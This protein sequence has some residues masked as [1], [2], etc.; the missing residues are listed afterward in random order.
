MA[1]LFHDF[2]F[3]VRALRKKP[4]FAVTAV[5]TLALG[6]GANVAVFSIVNALILRPYP[7]PELDRL[8]LLRA[9]GPKVVSEVRIAPAD[10]LDLQR[11][12]SIFQMLAAFRV[13]DSNLTGSGDTQSVVTAAVSPNFFELIGVQPTLGRQF[14]TEETE[15]GRDAV[16]IL[17]YGFW[18][19]HFSG[20]RNI[21]GRSIELDGRKMA[22]VG[23]M[24][25]H[26]RYPVATDLWMPLVL[27]PQTRAE[28]NAQAV[29]GRAIQVLARLRPEVSLN[30]AESEVQ[31][32]AARLQR[33][34]PDTHSDRSLSL[35]LL[36]REQYAFSAPL[37][38]TL[39]AAALFVL[40]LAA[41]N[42]FNLLLA[43][44]IDRQ[45]DVAVRTALG[46]S[47]LR[48]MQLYMGETV[49]LALVGGGTALIGSYLAVNFIRTS[50]PQ[51][52]TKW[53]AGW[54]SIHLDW[55][56]IEFAFI[57]TLL[58][59]ILFAVGASW[60]SG[61]PDLNHVLKQ[62]TRASGRR[63][64]RLRGILVTAQIAFA[65]VLLAGA[66]LMVQGFIRL[67][68][69]YKTFDPGHVLTMEITLPEQRYNDDAKVRAF[70]QQFLERVAALPG[71][72]SAGTVTNPPASNVDNARS[73]FAIEGQT[74]LRES[75][76]PSADL[77]SVSPD[78]FRSLRIPLLQGRD[79][80]DHDG[81]GAP[82]VAMISRTM[83]TRL[84]PGASA[85]GQRIKLGSPGSQANW[86]TIVGVVEDVKQNWW[87]SAA[88][89][90]I[91]RPFAQVPRRW[92]NFAIRTSFDP[93]SVASA[94]REAGHSLDPGVSLALSTMD[95]EVSDSLAPIRI[96]GILMVVFGAVSIALSALGIYG[97]LAHSVAQRTHEFGIRMALGAQRGDVLRLVIGQSWKLCAIG[98]LIGLP[99]AY[100]LVRL[101][102][103]LLYGV[104]AFSAV[105]F[106]V[107]AVALTA[108]A[109]LAGYLPAK[110]ATKVD[111]MLALRYE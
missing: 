48:L 24:P 73:L 57:L 56:V 15:A 28:R 59:G 13:G 79:V 45:K 72:L 60:R 3:G 88:R 32:F 109:L 54:E 29:Q 90:V 25:R 107:L 105:V 46:A 81:D 85:I 93:H 75:D 40:L 62:G 18:Q 101:I 91:Y 76:A 111:P 102:E 82:A 52:Y 39:Q 21:L 94:V 53:V 103:N 11:E 66:G 19:R 96:L 1:N 41:A 23:I 34:F 30:R 6:I 36:R 9:E 95:S 31:A 38:L 77:Q 99:S 20:V 98:L 27:T 89:P 55:S 83:A 26:F 14:A 78:F 61:A 37:F 92:M 69:V 12:S 84:W 5:L 100:L 87:D 42:L 17:N 71:V 22:I 51:D 47:K 108:V 43:R 80:T 58:V 110:R 68:R 49:S 106:I 2:R 67:A 8:V 4:G 97:L 16:V 70:H 7:F 104:I 74:I 64:G 33:Q 63:R 10:F 35:L 44:L 50:I 65:A 86:I